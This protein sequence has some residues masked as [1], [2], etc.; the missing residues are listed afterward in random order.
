[1]GIVLVQKLLLN[2][3][4]NYLLNL[5]L[6]CVSVGLCA[7]L[8]FRCL[9]PEEGVQPLKLVLQAARREWGQPCH[10]NKCS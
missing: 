7:P 5:G 8:P 3:F 1:M 2:D 9:W 6:S 10:V 4:L